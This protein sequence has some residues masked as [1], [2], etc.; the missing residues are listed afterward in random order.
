MSVDR[1]RALEGEV[2]A[3]DRESALESPYDETRIA[4]DAGELGPRSLEVALVG[5]HGVQGLELGRVG[6][7]LLDR[8]RRLRGDARPGDLVQAP[9]D[10]VRLLDDREALL[11][12]EER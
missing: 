1:L 3:V 5:A 11:R 2:R 4:E 6:L 10:L 7:D 8:R 12:S 9:G